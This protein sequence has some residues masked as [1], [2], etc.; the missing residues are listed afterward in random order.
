MFQKKNAPSVSQIDSLIGKGTRIEG[1]VR[2][3]GGLR[4]DGE[5]CGE[6]VADSA[7]ATLSLSESGVIKG[8][9]NASHLILNGTVHGPVQA[10]V[11]LD[12]QPKARVFGD[13]EYALIE[14]Q[15]GATIE[16]RMLLLAKEGEKAGYNDTPPAIPKE[17][18]GA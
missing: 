10:G 6:V 9:V 8:R 15:Q 2:F 13:V 1:N 11:F 7:P 3:S 18:S 4:V 14:M 16:G 12:M 5:I 17:K